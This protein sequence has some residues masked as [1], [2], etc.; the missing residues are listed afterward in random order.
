MSER[1]ET[2]WLFVLDSRRGRLL[3]TARAPV[4]R[5]HLDELDTMENTREQHQHGRPSRRTGKDTH[6]Y[7]SPGHEDDELLQRY[8]DDVA[9]WMG[10]QVSKRDIE[11]VAVFAPIRL[12][13]A[14]RRSYSEDLAGR[15][16][17]HGSDL[18]N[19]EPG[20]LEQHPAVLSVL[21]PPDREPEPVS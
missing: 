21:E 18:G 19:L 6:S 8:A 16:E 5:H 12:L 3:R 7:A 11:R 9:T 13:G 1:M 4:G 15:V 10:S 14:L 20:Q 2:T 17:E